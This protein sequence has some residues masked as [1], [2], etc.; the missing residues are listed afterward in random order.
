[1]SRKFDKDEFITLA[2]FL[3]IAGV[4]LPIVPNKPIV[5]FLEITPF[6]IWIA[7]VVIS[8]ISYLSY[9]LRKFV[10]M[11]SGI[12]VSALLGGLYSST[13]VTVILSKKGK[14][15]DNNPSPFATGIILS[16][17]MMYLRILVLMII[18]NYKLSIMLAPY[19]VVM[20]LVS[21]GAA[22][23]L[24]LRNKHFEKVLVPEITA[25][26]NPLEFKVAI[27]F[28]LLFVAF[29]FI[30]Y[31]VIEWFGVSG[32]NAL[33]WLVGISDIDPFLL[34]LFQGEFNVPVNMVALSCMQA[35]ISNNIIKTLYGSFLAGPKLRKMIVTGMLII[36]IANSVLLFFLI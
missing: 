31:Y 27:I 29:S 32:L 11:R 13:A 28:T 15:Y 4:I 5:P 17:A 19:F 10:F 12:T 25:D 26:K 9:L 21:I 1:M 16:M 14:N 34:N 23:V 7:V 35:V 20:I 22:G 8:G 6:K 30:T 36:I 24:Y 2:K 33:S 18:F 3:A